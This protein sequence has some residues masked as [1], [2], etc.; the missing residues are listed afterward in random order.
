MEKLTRKAVV[1][2]LGVV[3]ALTA[4]C[5]E[6][7]LSSTKK[8]RLVAVENRQLKKQLEQRRKEIER[9]KKLH[10]MEME[11]QRGLLEKCL[12]RTKVLQEQAN[13]EF[14]G[15]VDGISDMFDEENKRLRNENEKLKAQVKE[16]QGEKDN[17]KVEIEKLIKQVKE[18]EAR[19]GPKPL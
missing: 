11:K 7:N 3:I 5:E 1:L 18:P 16:L 10:D 9:Q 4:G 17:L 14:K 6:A 13:E 15:L 19:A 8:A 2:A 12:Q